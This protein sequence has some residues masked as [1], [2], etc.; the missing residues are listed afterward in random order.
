MTTTQGPSRPQQSTRV[1]PDEER[2]RRP[3]LTGEESVGLALRSAFP[4]SGNME[5]PVRLTDFPKDLQDQAMIAYGIPDDVNRALVKFLGGKPYTDRDC[6]TDLASRRR[7]VSMTTEFVKSV[8]CADMGCSTRRTEG[9]RAEG[10]VY[11]EW[12][13]A[14]MAL[15]TKYPDIDQESLKRKIYKNVE[16]DPALPWQRMII[17]KATVRV[18]DDDGSPVTFEAMGDCCPHSATT[19]TASAIF[20][21]AET[22]SLNRA[23]RPAVRMPIVSMEERGDLII[24][25]EARVIGV[26]RD[27]DTG[28]G[29]RDEPLPDPTAE[30]QREL[31][32]LMGQLGWTRGK[33][34]DAVGRHRGNYDAVITEMKAAKRGKE[35]AHG[36]R[37][38]AGVKQE[39]LV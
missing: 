19:V 21:M 31:E 1:A 8:P 26:E 13:E 32:L 10:H 27:D 6:L 20:R 16:A 37:D 14:A 22:R 15:R 17:F 9:Y 5:R 30:Q 28:L 35:E 7:L 23:L 2:G 4:P 34:D 24:D 33:F 11:G 3:Q 25:A 12:R 38:Q 36:A 29:P 18:R 39:R